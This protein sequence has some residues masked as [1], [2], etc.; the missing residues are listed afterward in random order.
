MATSQFQAVADTTTGT[1]QG[2][3]SSTLNSPLPGMRVR[4]SSANARPSNHDPKTPTIVKMIVN[5]VAFQ[6]DSDVRTVT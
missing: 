6:N 4:S 1:T 5:R 3:N 2:S